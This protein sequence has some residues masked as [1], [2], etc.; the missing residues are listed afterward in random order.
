M[1]DW[2]IVSDIVGKATAL[3]SVGIVG[4]Y[5]VRRA[6]KDGKDESSQPQRPA[7]NQKAS[8]NPTQT[9]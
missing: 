8:S 4:A 9:L 3:A 5:M 7:E 6:I 2:A 1:I